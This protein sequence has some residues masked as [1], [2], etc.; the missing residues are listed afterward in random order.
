MV[1]TIQQ[2]EDLKEWSKDST[3]YERRLAW[4]SQSGPG[5]MGTEAGT[6]PIEWDELSDREREYYRTGP[7]STREDYRKGQL[8]QPGPGRQGYAGDRKRI[9]KTKTS[10]YSKLPKSKQGIWR[11]QREGR[12]KDLWQRPGESYRDFIKRTKDVKSQERMVSS[13][14]KFADWL[15]T[16]YGKNKKI[17][18]R[19]SELIG[20]SG[21]EIEEGTARTY[22]TKNN[23]SLLNKVRTKGSQLFMPEGEGVKEL[24][25]QRSKVSWEDA[26]PNKRQG[27]MDTY[28]D[29]LTEKAKLKKGNY[30]SADELMKMTG[31]NEYQIRESGDT[32]IGRY[33]R[34]FL[35]P[36]RSY[37]Q[38][39]D[40]AG[41]ARQLNYYKK[42]TEIQLNKLKEFTGPATKL[43]QKTV[44]LINELYP[45]Y[46]SYYR[47]G[48]LPPLEKVLEAFPNKTAHSIGFA[49]TRIAQ[50]L[51]GATFPKDPELMKIAQD[52]DKANLLFE[53]FDKEPWGTP[54]ASGIR[55]VAMG[56]IESKLGYDPGTIDQFKKM[57]SKVLKDNHIPL[58]DPKKKYSKN[59]FGFQIDEF[60]GITGSGRSKAPEFSQFINF[61]EGKMN[62]GAMA[63]FQKE[64]N[65]T[66]DAIEA[67]PKN[68]SKELKKFKKI[69]D[70]YVQT[71][72]VDLADI[73]PGLASK[74]YS[75]EF[76]EEAKKTRQV[77]RRRI[78]G[79]DLE[80][81]SKRVGHTVIVPEEYRTF[82]QALEKQNRPTLTKN[83]KQLKEGVMK[84]FGEYDEKK[85][86]KKFYKYMD[87][88]TPSQIKRIMKF[89]PKIA[90]ADDISDRRYASADNI[91]TDAT[92]VDDTEENFFKRNPKTVTAAAATPLAV[93]GAAKYR[94]PL[95]TAAKKIGSAALGPTGAAGL[96]YGLGGIDLKDPWDRGGLAAEAA[97]A[98]SLVKSTEYASKGIKNPL[99]K[100]GVQRALNLGMSLPMA[101]RA[102]RIASP[103]GWLSLAGEG[104]YHAGKR[105]M[106]RREQMSPQEL[107]DFHLERQS[108]GWSRMGQADGG[109]T[110][111]RRPWAI[112]PESGPMPQGGGL[113]SQFNRVKKLTG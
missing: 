38:H 41:Q 28:K 23:K 83:I 92:Y 10:A 64:F 108:R 65:K 112:P 110:N 73:K 29:I 113:S 42:P 19:M 5:S 98:P 48:E 79:I 66:R 21:I 12:G 93:A 34:K 32:A 71:L 50:M 13:G 90:Q 35:K 76:L 97:L 61:A 20:E 89:I 63:N 33:V 105:E 87:E 3:R 47:N 56:A 25:D 36:V 103:I 99:V 7:W 16:N 45:K 2:L 40:K 44:D 67:N 74:H 96:W 88:A 104:I 31:L 26:S 51:D 100:K 68:M 55:S 43:R 15:E 9:F 82:S 75:K 49:E 30:I 69:R 54:R 101:M 111:V 62:M 77:G 102:A 109:I 81:A 78:P 86:F 4:R 22:L 8:V 85:A 11:W 60:A 24:W 14:E 106:A 46:R 84:F 37:Q 6:I 94:K 70:G 58:Y 80:A 53:A 59:N 72:G 91:M 18:K 39:F 17:N 27:F 1:S 95:S 107:E 57:M 52:K